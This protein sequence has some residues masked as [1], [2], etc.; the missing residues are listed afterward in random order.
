LFDKDGK[1][2]AVIIG[3]GGFLGMGEKD[4]ALP[5]SQMNMTRDEN[6]AVKLTVTASREE[7][8]AAPAFDPSIFNPTAPANT[9]TTTPATPGKTSTGG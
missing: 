5:L 2:K 1:V 8:N 6:G 3:V 9:N 7:L 4:V